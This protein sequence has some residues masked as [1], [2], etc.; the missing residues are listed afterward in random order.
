MSISIKRRAL[1][2]QSAPVLKWVKPASARRRS[3]GSASARISPAVLAR[4]TILAIA[5]V[6]RAPEEA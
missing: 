5:S 3:A 1:A 6:I 4:S 2:S